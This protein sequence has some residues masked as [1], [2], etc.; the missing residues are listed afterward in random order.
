VVN[1]S[2]WIDMVLAHVLVLGAPAMLGYAQTLYMLP[3]GIFGM[4]I[5]A[6]ELPELS[7]KRGEVEKVLVPRVRGALDRLAFLLVPSALAYLVLGDVFIAALFQRGVFSPEAT[8]ATHAVLA[9]YALGLPASAS[10]RAL[11]STFYALRD[12]RTPA[13]IATMRVVISVAVGAA[14]MFPLDRF[15]VGELRFGAAG[16]ALGSAVGAWVEYIRLRRSLTRSLGPHGPESRRV[17]RFVI[18]GLVA[19]AAGA[20]A[21][22][23]L[24][25]SSDP[26]LLT[27]WLGDTSFWVN[28]L[29]AMGTAAAFGVAYLGTTSLLGAG[30]AARG[31]TRPE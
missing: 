3:I 20:G 11:S 19:A 7:R 18:S 26:G 6:S 5:A 1:V 24:G 17:I 13:A 8:A 16:L 12:T 21:K 10:S 22:A 29:A 23:G 15:G 28:P 25:W 30:L 4:A 9:A 14:L 27:S 31:R 2:G